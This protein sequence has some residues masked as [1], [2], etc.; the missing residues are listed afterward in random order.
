MEYDTDND[1][2]WVAPQDDNY[3]VAEWK[4]LN[5]KLDAMTMRRLRDWIDG[6]EDELYSCWNFDGPWPEFE[7]APEEPEEVEYQ[8]TPRETWMFGRKQRD[9]RYYRMSH[10]GKG[11][12]GRDIR[13]EWS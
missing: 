12:L 13:K 9:T 4:Y 5:E 2:N 1:P 3:D 11:H 8:P 7:R 6:M 10:S